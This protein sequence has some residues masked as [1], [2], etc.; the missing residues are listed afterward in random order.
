M[1]A[2]SCGRNLVP[3]KLCL[4]GQGAAVLF[5][6]VRVPEVARTLAHAITLNA[7]EVCCTATRWLVHEAVWDRFLEFA[8]Q[9]LGS[10]SIGYG[11]DPE[12]DIGP[13]VSI[14]QQDRV[15]GYLESAEQEGAALEFPG[16]KAAVSGY[17]DGFYLKPA[18]LTG[19]PASMC[20]RQQIHGP[21]A[22][23]MRFQDEVEAIEIANRSL[24][25][26]ANSVWSRDVVR[27][28]RVAEEL[29]ARNTWIN[30]HNIF[31]HGVPYGGDPSGFG[32]GVLGPNSLSDYQR[33]Q[34]ITRPVSYQH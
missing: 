34:T 19:N 18:L 23:A 21:V 24:F 5:E 3:V 30:A 25:G 13:L 2:E 22:F 8:S 10:M 33:S 17:E 16:G 4:G 6:D 31:A 32:G 26:F 12:T 15:L 1:V 27:A 11:A 29:V 20:A 28:I 14:E 7:G 9:A